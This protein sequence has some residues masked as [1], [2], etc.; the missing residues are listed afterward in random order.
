MLNCLF[1]YSI[2]YRQGG[3]EYE[4]VDIIKDL[5]DGTI[6]LALLEVLTGKRLVRFDS[7]MINRRFWT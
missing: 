2:F 6:L 5:Q 1:N 3:K 4:I 7:M